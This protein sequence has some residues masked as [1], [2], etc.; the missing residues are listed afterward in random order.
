MGVNVAAKRNHIVCEDSRSSIS[1]NGRNVLRFPCYFCL[2]AE[3]LELTSDFS[4]QVVEARE[5]RLHRFELANCLLFTPAVF[6][7]AGRF[8][9]ESAAILWC[10]LKHRVKSSLTDDDVHL[11]AETRIG[12][13]LLHVEQPTRFAVD[14]VF[15]L[16]AAEKDSGDGDF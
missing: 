11:S 12:Q 2:L 7:N 15:A 3:R 13:Q 4:R 10:R 16:A 5:V 8:L 9:N 14:G 6:E 1:H